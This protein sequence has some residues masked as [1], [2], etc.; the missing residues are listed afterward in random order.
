[1]RN[2]T[3]QNTA[4]EEGT[5][6]RSELVVYQNVYDTFLCLFN[7]SHGGSAKLDPIILKDMYL[8]LDG[9]LLVLHDCSLC[10]CVQLIL[11]RKS[12]TPKTKDIERFS[13][14]L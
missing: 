9:H 1:M 12:D 14:T 11:Q 8:Q 13:L 10:R 2:I 3:K 6:Q 7:K 5:V 4:T